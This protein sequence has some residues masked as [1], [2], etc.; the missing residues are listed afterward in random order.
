MLI[1]IVRI[2]IN[3][4]LA[5]KNPTETTK[6]N[7]PRITKKGKKNPRRHSGILASRAP[8]RTPTPLGGARTAR[9]PRHKGAGSSPRN[10]PP[11]PRQLSPRRCPAGRGSRRGR[12]VSAPRGGTGGPGRALTV[13]EATLLSARVK[14]CGSHRRR[15]LEVRILLRNVRGCRM[16]HT[17]M[18][19]SCSSLYLMP[20]QWSRALRH[21]AAP[22]L[23]PSGADISPSS[24]LLSSVC[25]RSLPPPEPPVRSMAAP[26]VGG[27]A[28]RRPPR[29]DR[30]LR[31]AETG[32]PNKITNNL[33]NKQKEEIQPHA[34][35]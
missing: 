27:G 3:I 17:W 31:A 15:N 5:Q 12:A 26:R 20:L 22:I 13:A 6:L 30:S 7:I 33:K 29:G 21:G 28:R 10:A 19:P 9:R 24:G 4:R 25:L 1:I 14:W 32:I 8:P 2:I 18:S 11:A 16:T 35:D 34:A 23:F